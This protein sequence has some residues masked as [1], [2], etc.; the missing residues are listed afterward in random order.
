M[1]AAAAGVTEAVAAAAATSADASGP[2]RSRASFAVAAS[3]TMASR[4]GLRQEEEEEEDFFPRISSAA[5]TVASPEASPLAADWEARRSAS[6]HAPGAART[7]VAS[8]SARACFVERPRNPA[9]PEETAAAAETD[10]SAK[11]ASRS[12]SRFAFFATSEADADADADACLSSPS[13]KSPGVR[14][15]APC[16]ST[17]LARSAAPASVG[18]PDATAVAVATATGRANARSTQRKAVSK[19]FPEI[20][21]FFASLASRVSAAKQRKRWKAA[22]RRA[23]GAST[24]PPGIEP[25]TVRAQSSTTR[26]ITRRRHVSS[27]AGRRETETRVSHSAAARADF[28]DVESSKS[29]I[30][31]GTH[32]SRSA[33]RN[34]SSLNEFF[35]VFVSSF[36]VSSSATTMAP[37]RR[38]S[39]NACSNAAASAEREGTSH[40]PY[41]SQRLAS[42][43]TSRFFFRSAPRG[44]AASRGNTEGADASAAP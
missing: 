8:V 4:A 28:S 19:S 15:D 31:A 40:N 12:P 44:V 24:P 26:S 10:D 11:Q 20:S 33:A 3:T 6:S 27:S 9:S 29:R 5:A 30:E 16:F 36:D 41:P 14:H 38:V 32:R 39:R 42:S 37:Y 23:P 34:R 2:S 13:A 17:R 7:T 25:A 21:F 18:P 35:S 1:A 43:R 22:T